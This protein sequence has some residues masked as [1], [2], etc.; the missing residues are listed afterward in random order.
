MDEK[1]KKWLEEAMED[2]T[3]NEI[4]RMKQ[5]IEILEK[6]EKNTKEDEETRLGLLEEL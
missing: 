6:E 4:K 5:I 3:F 2:Y 1:T